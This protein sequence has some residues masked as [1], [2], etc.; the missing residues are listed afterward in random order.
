MND[1][2][3]KVFEALDDWCT[4]RN[5]PYDVACDEDDLQGFMLFRR[6]AKVVPQ[7][8]SFLEPLLVREGLHQRTIMTNSGPVLA[9]S[10]QALSEDLVQ[11]FMVD[12]AFH[13]KIAAVFDPINELQYNFPNKRHNIKRATWTKI[14]AEGLL[15][16][17]RVMRS[18]A[19]GQAVSENL[20]GLGAN[21]QPRDILKRLDAAMRELNLHASLKARGITNRVHDD[22][23]SII[24]FKNGS[25]EVAFSLV[26][27][28]ERNELQGALTKLMDLAGGNAMGAGDIERE[29]FKQQEQAVSQI[30]QN[31]ATPKQKEVPMGG[32][33]QPNMLQQQQQ[34][35]LGQPAPTAPAGGVAGPAPMESRLAEVFRA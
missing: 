27:L 10:L 26:K 19:L 25:P 21:F 12:N 31:Y 33:A 28:G 17:R 32:K 15:P 13:A 30:A 9:F 8:L 23:Q 22:G 3:R 7:L 11:Q 29:K 6:D 24:F 18:A 2:L 1:K 34:Q 5:V 16:T 35:N 14:Q 4:R 20:M